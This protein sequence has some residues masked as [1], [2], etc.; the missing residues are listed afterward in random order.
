MD[1]VQVHEVH[2]GKNKVTIIADPKIRGYHDL[3][4]RGGAFYAVY[5]PESHFWSRDIR[6]LSELI[7]NDINQYYDDHIQELEAEGYTVS[8]HL[9]QNMSNGAWNRYMNSFKYLRDNEETLDQKMIFADQVPSREDYATM[10]L[11]YSVEPGVCNSYNKLMSVLYSADQ[12]EKLEWGIGAL[13]DGTQIDQIQKMFVIYGDP[14]TGKSTILN[15]IEEL[16][17]GYIA[18]F[19]ADELGKGY[20]FATAAFKNSPLIGI[21]HDGDLSKMWD[22]TVLNELAAHE[23]IVVNEKGVKQYPIRPKTMLFMA[24]NKAVKITDSKAGLIRRLIDIEPTGTKMPQDEYFEAIGQ[25]KFELG[26]I[27][28]HC[29]SVYK[30]RGAHYYDGYSPLSMISRT[31]DIYN[32]IEDNYGLVTDADDGITLGT[33]W[34]AFK[35]WQ[36]DTKNQ[37]VMKRTDFMYEMAS[38]YDRMER[39]HHVSKSYSTSGVLFYGFKFDKFESK[40]ER[41]TVGTPDW[42]KLDSDTSAFDAMAQSYSAQLARNDECGAPRVSWDKCTTTLADIDTHQLHWVRVPSN[43][44]VLDF[45]LRGEDGEKS[46]EANIEAAKDFPKTYAEVSKSGNGLHLHY[47][48]D[49][50]VDKLK[51]LY[52]TH[53]EVKVYKGKS[54]LRRKLSKCN[55]LEVAHISSG[56]PLKG[57]KSMI[58]KSELADE[59]HLRNIIKNCLLK[60]Y[61]PGTKPSI[62]FICKVLDEAYEQGLA[63]DVSDMRNDILSF[64]MHSS[65]WADYCMTVVSNMKFKSEKMPEGKSDESIDS[66][67]FYDVEVFPNLFMICY[68]RDDEDEVHCWINPP[69]KSVMALMEQPLVGFNNRR[70][71]NHM[72][73]AWGGLGYDN[74]QLYELSSKIVNGDKNALF[75]QAYNISY[76]D[77]YDFSSKKQSLKKWEIELGID[78][79]ELG[80]DWTKPVPEDMWKVVEGYCKDDVRA[81]KAVFHHLSGDFEARKI[82]AQLSGLTVNDTNNTHTAKIIFGNEMHPQSSFN[83]PDL[84]ELFPGYVFDPYA[85]KDQKSKYMGEYPSEGGYVFVYGMDNGDLDQDYM[86][87]KHPWEE[88]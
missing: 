12:R 8:R 74:S 52:S 60:K 15:I 22:N 37:I 87:I 67:I 3:L 5:D 47:I 21:Q 64:A 1:Q 33:L 16:F 40:I 50:D 61:Q 43:H 73:Y 23:T 48:Y 4:V 20:T 18:Y 77:I 14:G 81:T 25:I 17:P 53:I 41:I 76:A 56:L 42:L 2:T 66:V 86:N 79:H 72:L 29:L 70:Y 83:Y 69:R 57:E 28:Y 49:G 80:M 6:K 78:H 62:D 38:Y 26:A 44:I 65:H 24:T 31:N 36:D 39:T 30:S 63:Y 88:Q 32:F 35:E 46:L 59:Q 68:M 34:T 13:V 10:Q 54:A 58:N 71:D 51:N 7:D 75:G 84:A 55:D 27:A 19:S 11:P 45:D 85:P 9:M 82:L